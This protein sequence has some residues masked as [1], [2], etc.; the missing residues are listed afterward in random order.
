M[1]LKRH[2][3]HHNYQSKGIYQ[4]NYIYKLDYNIYVEYFLYLYLI[5]NIINNRIIGLWSAKTYDE[6]FIIISFYN[7]TL[8]LNS[9]KG[10]LLKVIIV[11]NNKLYIYLII[12]NSVLN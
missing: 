1:V 8:I 2:F 10:E 12:Y 7:N 3:F 6:Q 11:Y 5:I 4:L 9:I